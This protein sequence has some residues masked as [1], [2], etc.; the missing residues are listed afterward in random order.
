MGGV[1]TGLPRPVLQDM[2]YMQEQKTRS[3]STSNLMVSVMPRVSEY[4][5]I[6]KDVGW[7]VKA[8]FVQ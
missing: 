7:V 8:L 4:A 5:K 1:E 6:E 2:S 3:R